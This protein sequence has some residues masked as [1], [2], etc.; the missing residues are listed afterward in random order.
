MSDR[1]SWG[2]CVLPISQEVVAFSSCNR[3]LLGQQVSQVCAGWLPGE[4]CV[5][6]I[7]SS[8]G[9]LSHSGLRR[10]NTLSIPCWGGLRGWWAGS[11]LPM[12]GMA[13]VA[14][15]AQSS[16]PGAALQPPWV[17][18]LPQLTD[19]GSKRGRLSSASVSPV[20]THLQQDP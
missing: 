16:C 1:L 5:L 7:L 19:P 20:V 12:Q 2:P 14:L 18:S 8:L 9:R 11:T 6:H 3:L 4:G 10:L 13:D 15:L 17:P